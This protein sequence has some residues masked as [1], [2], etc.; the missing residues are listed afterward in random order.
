MEVEGQIYKDHIG[1]TEEEWLAETLNIYR[2]ITATLSVTEVYSIPA[3]TF[4][5]LDYKYYTI[6]IYLRR[7]KLI[8]LSI[9]IIQ[10]LQLKSRK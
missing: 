5:V 10:K 9:F 4:H 1:F 6:F 3:I 8:D 7:G 2:P